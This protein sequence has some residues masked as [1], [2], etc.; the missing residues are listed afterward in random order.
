MLGEIIG[1]GAK[2]LGGF[3]GQNSQEKIA[4][5]NIALQKDFAQQ[6]I[7]WKVDD[8]KAAGI[9]PLAALGTQTTSF[10]PISVGTPLADSIGS[11]GQDISRAVNA[12]QT[13]TE[14]AANTRALNALS[15]ERGA[16]ENE[17]LRG[18]IRAQRAPGNPPGLPGLDKFQPPQTTNSLMSG[19]ERI[20]TSPDFSDQ[21]AFEDR[22]GE[23][24]GELYGIR[25][26]LNEVARPTVGNWA[27]RLNHDL[28]SQGGLPWWS[29]RMEE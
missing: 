20:H 5:E 14:D 1:A 11:A 6:G 28:W 17:L 22:Y 12:Q 27:Y 25:S 9:H 24:V 13:P 29:P 7:R 3:L 21:Q 8:A 15:L 23:L 2:L 16:L 26:W 19:G 10:S 4:K 18:R